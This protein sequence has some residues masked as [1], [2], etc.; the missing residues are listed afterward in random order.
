MVAAR[1]TTATNVW[2]SPPR[3]LHAGLTV[4]AFQY[5]EAAFHATVSSCILLAKLP[6][7]CLI[8]DFALWGAA[9]DLT[10]GSAQFQANA[11]HLGGS[12]SV[13]ALT[14]RLSMAGAPL[15]ISLSD[16]AAT[17]Y[18]A[19]RIMV[20]TAASAS[21]TLSLTGWVAYLCGSNEN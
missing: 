6:P 4:R 7:H 17:Q 8:T 19:L 16:D 10:T 20:T 9:S 14:T 2:A 15:K 12:I 3:S 11:T 21:V 18:A 5:S 13:A 1:T